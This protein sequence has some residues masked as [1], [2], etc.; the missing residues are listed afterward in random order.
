MT[1]T[2]D[3][4]AT[5]AVSTTTL[6]FGASV[7]GPAHLATGRPNED[8]W[9]G[10]RAA[11]GTAIVVS[12]GVGSAPDAKY[13]ATRACET[14]INCLHDWNRENGREMDDLV[15]RIKHLWQESIAP[16]TTSDCAATCLFAVSRPSGVVHIAGVGDGMALIRRADAT[17]QWVVGPRIAAFGGTT[18]DMG[19]DAGWEMRTV[20]WRSGDI[21]VLATDG[22]ADDV[23]EERAGDFAAWLVDTFAPMPART[24]WR[25]LARELRAWPTPRPRAC[26]WRPARTCSSCATASTSPCRPS[27]LRLLGR[28]GRLRPP[29]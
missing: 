29:R 24:R 7:T 19:S 26:G 1:S 18:D 11:F 9:L 15:R 6:F 2:S 14:V 23:V 25:V 5:H 28:K 21:V 20:E 22:V 27:R 16:L 4:P 10:R 8:R 17:T 3:R 13:G 12:D